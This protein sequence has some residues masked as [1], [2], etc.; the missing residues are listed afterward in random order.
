[1]MIMYV[2][3]D[4]HRVRYILCFLMRYHWIRKGLSMILQEMPG[5][6]F[7]RYRN[8]RQRTC[9]VWNSQDKEFVRQRIRKARIH[10]S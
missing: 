1:M 7:V 5:R 4:R 8:V 9:K 6:Q 3:Y 10:K 2:G